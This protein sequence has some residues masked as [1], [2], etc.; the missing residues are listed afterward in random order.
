SFYFGSTQKNT[1]YINENIDLD[2]TKR[3]YD[4]YNGASI[5]AGIQYNTSSSL[6]WQ[7]TFGLTFSVS[8]K[9]KGFANT[10]YLTGDLDT[11]FLVKSNGKVSFNMP[12]STVL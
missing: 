2:I 1:T 3:E 8:S 4:F 12:V 10:E 6:Y 11:A 5:L 9:L 7:Q